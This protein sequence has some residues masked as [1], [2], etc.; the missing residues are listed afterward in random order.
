MNYEEIDHWD[1]RLVN[2]EVAEEET[3]GIHE[4]YY[5]KDGYPVACTENPVRVVG[6]NIAE[7]L[8]EVNLMLRACDKPIMY[9]NDINNSGG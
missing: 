4:V 8:R 5:N 9:Y 3:V 6:G 2:K 7:A 1:Y